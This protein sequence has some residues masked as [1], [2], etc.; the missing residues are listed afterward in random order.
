MVGRKR[1]AP[2]ASASNAAA[3]RPPR[4][5][6]SSASRNDVPDIYREMLAEAD[7]RPANPSSAP[8]AKRRK[9]GQRNEERLKKTNRP[10]SKP[11]GRIVAP[12]IASEELDQEEEDDEDIYFEDVSLPVA[13]VQTI[14]RDSDEEDEEEDVDIDFE[15]VELS[16]PSDPLEGANSA[17]GNLELDLSTRAT[18]TAK[19]TA[20]RRKPIGKAEK[21]RRVEVHKMHLLCLFSHAAR[22][23]RWCN[24][25]VVHDSL[26][27]LLSTKMIKYLNPTANLT[28]FGQANSLKEGLQQVNTM[29]RMKYQV[30]E[31]GLRRSLWAEKEEH[32]Q[33]YQLPEDAETPLEKSDFQEAAKSLQGS[34]DVGAQLYCAL[35]RSA[36]VEARLVCSLQPLPIAPGGPSMSKP[37]KAKVKLSLE[38]QYARMP[39]YDSSFDSPALASR[40]FPVRRRLGHPNATA[41]QAPTTISPS[42]SKTSPTAPKSLRPVDESPFPVY[43][44]EILD[45]GHQKW[46]PTDP[47][48]TRSFWKPHQLEPPASDRQNHMAYVVGFED[49]GTAKDVTRRYAQA[50]N[51]KTRKRRIEAASAVGERWWRKALRAHSRAATDLD[52]IE[53]VE[54]NRIESLEPMPRNVVDFKD[55]PIYALERHLRRHEVLV[56]GA[57]PAGTV[58]A[59]SKGPLERIYRRSDVRI[60]RSREKWYRLGREVRPDEVPVKF[61]TK[62]TAPPRE[63]DLFGDEMEEELEAGGTVGTPIFTSEQTEVYKAQPVVDG[64]IP[65]N[66][67]GNLDIFVPSMV[68]EGGSYVAEELGARAAWLL[69]IDYAPALTGFHFRGRKG[70]AVLYGAVVAAE[71]EEAVRAVIQGLKDQEADVERE[72]RSR[73]VLRAWRRFLMNLRVRERIW[74][75]A[76]S[77]EEMK[78]SGEED[79]RSMDKGKEIAEDDD[80]AEMDAQPGDGSDDEDGMAGGF[81]IDDD[82]AGGFTVE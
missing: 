71:N 56:P 11:E 66:R 63:T 19:K 54:L 38:E 72:R 15:D 78:A 58:G 26:R 41:F 33:N 21:D 6:R 14:L 74:A 5:T 1:K 7:V 43:W 25:P 9:P 68:P 31:R 35:L 82:Y 60:A 24:D 34:R 79:T 12:A 81:M 18:V 44:V 48:V 3:S 22:R 76:D 53:D 52:Q 28:P 75:G 39:K 46:Q 73:V 13:T 55:H 62:R 27:P 16:L 50:Y 67:F 2:G 70:T 10:S 64:R 30:T 32:L 29:F 45:E 77:D 65:K 36:G 47:F 40:K 4:A 23:N 80:A 17:L 59:G 49:D 8:A 57:S 61:L 37:P 69:G 20:D 42:S 51:A